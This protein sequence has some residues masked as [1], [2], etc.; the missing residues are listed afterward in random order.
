LAAVNSFQR[1]RAGEKRKL[2]KNA[3]SQ[4]QK[5]NSYIL[6]TPQSLGL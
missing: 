5:V 4:D 3:L 2:F 6:E 1:N